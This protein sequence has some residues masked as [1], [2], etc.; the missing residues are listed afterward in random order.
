MPFGLASAP[1]IF[2]SIV[3]AFI[4]PLHA[5]GLKLHFYLDDWLLRNAS[6]DIL[7]TQMKLLIKNVKLTGLIMNKEKS[8]LTP[9]QDFIFIGICFCTRVGLIFPPPDRIVKIM[10]RVGHLSRVLS[11]KGIL[12]SH[13]PTKLSGRSNPTREVVPPTSSASPALQMGDHTGIPWIGKFPFQ[14]PY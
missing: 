2:Q 10:S 4:A 13:W 6:K 1:L 3:K 9:S 7:K 12:K 14:N 8:E 5:L 11:G